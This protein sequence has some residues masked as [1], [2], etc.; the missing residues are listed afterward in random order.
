MGSA[1]RTWY[2]CRHWCSMSPGIMSLRRKK[3]SQDGSWGSCWIWGCLKRRFQGIL[4]QKILVFWT[5]TAFFIATRSSRPQPI[6]SPILCNWKMKTILGKSVTHTQQIPNQRDLPSWSLVSIRT[7]LWTIL[8]SSKQHRQQALLKNCNAR[9]K[10][11]IQNLGAKKVEMMLKCGS[12]SFKGLRTKSGTSPPTPLGNYDPSC[13]S[14]APDLIF[15]S[16]QPTRSSPIPLSY[17]DH[18]RTGRT[19]LANSGIDMVNLKRM[20]FWKSNKCVEGYLE[21]TRCCKKEGWT[22]SRVRSTV[23]MR[24]KCAGSS[25]APNCCC[26][27]TSASAAVATT[28]TTTKSLHNS[29]L[30]GNRALSAVRQAAAAQQDSNSR[31]ATTITSREETHLFP[32]TSTVISAAL[33]I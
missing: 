9:E 17:L 29:R 23:T 18:R 13:L 32:S 33:E 19:L 10:K 24:W 28:I 20:G 6:M 26:R 2:C 25:V 7:P 12:D 30:S 31:D 3:S 27:G 21:I 1:W 16:W 14:C 22:E 4:R 5:S 8:A 11:H 15:L